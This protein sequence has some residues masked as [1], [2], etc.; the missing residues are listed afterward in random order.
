[1]AHA[2]SFDRVINEGRKTVTV[3]KSTKR[4]KPVSQ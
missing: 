1:M 2:T 3:R 4:L